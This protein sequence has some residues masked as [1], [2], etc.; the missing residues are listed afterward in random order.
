MMGKINF[1]PK[2]EERMMDDEGGNGELAYVKWDEREWDQ[3]LV[4]YNCNSVVINY[5]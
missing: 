5:S 3:T 4:N 2:V 1:K